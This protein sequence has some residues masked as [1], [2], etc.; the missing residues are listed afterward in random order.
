MGGAFG[1]GL[2]MALKEYI[3]ANKLEHQV[4]ITLVVDFDPFQAGDM[5]AD[6]E[7]KT[8]QFVHKG[9]W[10][11]AG[12]G[13]LANEEEQGLSTRDIY[14][15]SGTSTDH[16]IFTFFGDIS[17]LSEGTYKWDGKNWVKQ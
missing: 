1:K 9:N 8:M 7:I 10:N 17:K 15:N 11:L 3:K 4:R 12:M 5:T 16:S 2:V 13:W 6:P 14:T